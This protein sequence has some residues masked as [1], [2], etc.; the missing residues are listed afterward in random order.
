MRVVPESLQVAA[1]EVA[2]RPDREVRVDWRCSKEEEEA[3][4]STNQSEE[5]TSGGGNPHT[6]SRTISPPRHQPN[7]ITRLQGEPDN[8]G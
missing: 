7:I 4:T 8:E 6:D 1:A 3:A 5:P 2:I